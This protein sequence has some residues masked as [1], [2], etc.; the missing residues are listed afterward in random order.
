M[1][2]RLAGVTIGL[3]MLLAVGAGASACSSGGDQLTLEEYFQKL[4]EADNRAQAGFD[5][6]GQELGEDADVE[7]FRAGFSALLEV[8]DGLLSDLGKL[9]PPDEVQEAHDEALDAGETVRDELARL[10][11]E[12]EDA[13]TIDEFFAAGGESFEA[14]D[15]RFTEACVGLE[16]IATSNDI[17]VDL[18]CNDEDE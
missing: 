4:E 9:E 8:V 3:G 14:A 15:A 16:E 10:L 11:E 1:I 12:G 7:D 17:T 2:R 5:D 13:T 6:A 18:D